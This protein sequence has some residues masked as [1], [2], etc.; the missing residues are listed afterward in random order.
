MPRVLTA[1]LLLVLGF[2]APL[3]L[4]P[5]VGPK[6][7]AGVLYC[8]DGVYP[9]GNGALPLKAFRKGAL[10][11]L[12][13]PYRRADWRLSRRYVFQGERMVA[14]RL[15]PPRP[16]PKVQ[17]GLVEVCL[18]GGQG[19]RC[20]ERPKTDWKAHWDAKTRTL[21]LTLTRRGPLKA[22]RVTLRFGEGACGGYLAY[23]ADDL[24]W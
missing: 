13:L 2:A 24:P 9:F 16:F 14:Q 20:R 23:R 3:K 4:D 8:P 17:I 7:A 10:L 18:K 12:A 15:R 11:R 21:W 22:V 6:D 19:W 5:L 1:V